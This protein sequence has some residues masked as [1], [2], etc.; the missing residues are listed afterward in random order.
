VGKVSTETSSANGN[1]KAS[2]G[3]VANGRHFTPAPDVGQLWPTLSDNVK[4]GIMAMINAAGG[5]GEG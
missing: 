1:G 5:T 2:N 4:A 3:E